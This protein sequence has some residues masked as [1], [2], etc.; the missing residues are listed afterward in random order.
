MVNA[1]DLLVGKVAGVAITSEN[2]TLGAKSNIRI[3]GGSSLNA[4]ND[5]LIVIDNVPIDNNGVKGVANI[6]SAINPQDIESFNVLKDASATAIYGS[7]GSNGV[8][9]ITTKKGHAGD[10]KVSYNGS[11]TLGWKKKTIDVLDAAGFRDLIRS[12]WARTAT[13]PCLVRQTPTG[14]I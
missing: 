5:P 14:R 11:V 1:Q 8:I 3:R 6:L 4:S 10:V 7:R 9:I 12:K 2:G 13:L